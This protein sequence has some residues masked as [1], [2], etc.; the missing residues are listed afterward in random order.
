MLETIEF[1][2]SITDLDTGLTNVD[3][4]TLTHDEYF[5]FFSQQSNRIIILLIEEMQVGIRAARA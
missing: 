3:R 4:N 5:K 2:A 1:P